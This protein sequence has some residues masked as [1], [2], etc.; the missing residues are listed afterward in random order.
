MNSIQRVRCLQ[1]QFILWQ[2]LFSHHLPFFCAKQVSNSTTRCHEQCINTIQYPLKCGCESRSRCTT[3]TLADVSN[4]G[5]GLGTPIF[6]LLWSS[7][8]P[9]GISSA[10]VQPVGAASFGGALVR[11]IQGA[12]GPAV[13]PSFQ[14]PKVSNLPYLPVPWCSLITSWMTCAPHS[15]HMWFSS[16][17]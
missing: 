7:S 2:W 16:C 14:G 5:M 9:P 12:I 11:F 3:V 15:P 8:R 10:G 1:F 4:I 13:W 17:F 6:T